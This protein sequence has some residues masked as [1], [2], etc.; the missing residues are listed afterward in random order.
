[1]A[2]DL[3]TTESSSLLG[4]VPRGNKKYVVELYLPCFSLINLIVLSSIL[5]ATTLNSNVFACEM[6]GFILLEF[7]IMF[8][9]TL[10]YLRQDDE[11]HYNVVYGSYWIG[12]AF[13]VD[14]A[15]AVQYAIV[16][17]IDNQESQLS[18]YRTTLL[19]IIVGLFQMGF[20]LAL[21]FRS[22]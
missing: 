3:R 20:V 8:L 9:G 5:W 4:N 15:C 14:L 6:V 13:L 12:A 7:Q 1:M 16:F 17:I 21:L 2:V 11:G 10:L 18:V 22:S 19:C